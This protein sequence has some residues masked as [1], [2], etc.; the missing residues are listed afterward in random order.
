MCVFLLLTTLSQ[1]PGLYTSLQMTQLCP[2]YGQV[3]FHCLYVPHPLYPSRQWASSCFH[4]LLSIVLQWTWGCMLKKKQLLS[5]G[6]Y[7]CNTGQCLEYSE[8][9]LLTQFCPTLCD[10]MDCSPPGSS[11]HGIL[12]ATILEWV[13]IPFSRGSSQS[14]DWTQISCVAGSLFT[15]WATIG[16]LLYWN[17]VGSQ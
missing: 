17:A 13:A 12:Q 6:S 15:I 16:K 10:P 1:I 5:Y 3:I 8:C 9:V 7:L 4:V 14:R 11:V 2:L